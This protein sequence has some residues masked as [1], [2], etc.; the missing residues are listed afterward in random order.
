MYSIV[1]PNR[2]RLDTLV[3][4]VPS[5]QAAPLVSEIVIVDFG[6]DRPM[7]LADIPDRRKLE[8]VEV[9]ATEEWRIGLA[10]NLGVDHAACDAILKLDSD[11]EITRPDWLSDLALDGAFYR[12]RYTTTVSNGQAV[13]L[14]RHWQAIGGYNEWLSGYGF[15]DS[16]FFMRDPPSGLGER[17][18]APGVR[19]ALPHSPRSPNAP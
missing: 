15:D 7:G 19:R 11:I 2:N 13:F 6:S 9:G 12:G 18:V 1:T 8:L 17:A 10:I 16:G 14:K 4:V 5:W 3:Q